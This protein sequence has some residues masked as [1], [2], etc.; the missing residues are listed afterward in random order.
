MTNCI[1]TGVA[2]RHHDAPALKK[3][4]KGRQLTLRHGGEGHG[5]EE[6]GDEEQGNRL[7]EAGGTHLRAVLE[8]REQGTDDECKDDVDESRGLEDGRV[9]SQVGQATLSKQQG[10]GQGSGGV[11]GRVGLLE[12]VQE[13]IVLSLLR[14]ILVLLEKLSQVCLGIGGEEAGVL[15]GKVL[16]GRR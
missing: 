12:L 15:L 2:C 10:L 14:V 9:T 16:V 6:G 8:S 7:V 1:R 4:C 13:G 5:G 11:L 3:K